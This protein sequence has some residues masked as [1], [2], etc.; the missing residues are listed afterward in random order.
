M[1]QEG[2]VAGVELHEDPTGAPLDAG[3]VHPAIFIE[4]ARHQAFAPT[5]DV[6]VD[7]WREVDRRRSQRRGSAAVVPPKP[8]GA[9]QQRDSHD[10]TERPV[11]N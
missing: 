5:A 8:A 3:Q 2:A 1:R 7:G 9:R 11:A 4:V 6:V 10:Q